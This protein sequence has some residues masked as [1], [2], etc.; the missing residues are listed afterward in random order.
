MSNEEITPKHRDK[1]EAL[2]NIS[3]GIS[4]VVA[5]ILGV[6]IGMGLKSWTGY[7]WTLW[8][9]VFWGIAA[10]VMNVYKAYK[11]AQKGYDELLKDPKYK[12]AAE[13]GINKDHDDD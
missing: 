11:K 8:I 1:I 7:G 10:A 2:D 12:Y 4:I 13:H 6:A 3:L 5:I 9:G